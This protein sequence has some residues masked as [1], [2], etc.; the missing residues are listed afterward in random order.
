[1]VNSQDAWWDWFGNHSAL[2]TVRD[3]DSLK[4][5]DMLKIVK[6]PIKAT[7]DPVLAINAVDKKVGER[8]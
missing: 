4:E 7:A 3:K 2:I 8:F 6:P 5:L 1:M